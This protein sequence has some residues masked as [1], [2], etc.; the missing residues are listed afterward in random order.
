MST[1]VPVTVENFARAETDMYFGMLVKRAG[2]VGRLDHL[3]ELHSI[4]GPGVRPNRDTL[5]SEAVFDLDAGP[6]ELTLPDA[7]D[8][9]LS[10]L[11]ID[12]DHYAF[13]AP[14]GAG[15]LTL[16]RNEIG[17]RYVFVAVRILADPAS[18]DDLAEV[19]AL[20]DAIRVTQA[21]SGGFEVPEWD[22][23][24]QKR[25]RDALL[26]LS[27]TLP[28]LRRGG[29]RRDE[30][31]PIRHLLATASGWGLNPDSEAVYLNVT[32]DRNDGTTAHTLTVKDV[33]VDGFWSISVY[34][35]EGHFVKNDRDAYT[36]N[37]L[38]AEP[39]PDGA[40]TIRFGGCNDQP[41]NCLPI[42]PGW[43][44]MV[45]LYRPRREILDDTWTLPQAEPH[46]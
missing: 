32:P 22:P 12:E 2:G 15:T 27:S 25:V 34:D 5:Y 10:V 39:G 42:F 40:V 33:P 20:Q 28:D 16:T 31:D 41:A 1:G 3:R 43:N 9:Y 7:G 23:E 37:S 13:M 14:R 35:S 44:Y 46:N 36:L 17:T 38:T 30:V 29:G 8:R 11:V 26:S 45:R 19:H 4:E 24:S 21:S 6:V 18:P